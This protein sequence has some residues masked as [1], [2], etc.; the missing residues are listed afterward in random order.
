MILID[1]SKFG[2][3]YSVCLT[4]YRDG[5][6]VL[7]DTLSKNIKKM[8]YFENLSLKTTRKGMSRQ[9]QE[10]CWTKD[11]WR[12]R[13]G[14]IVKISSRNRKRSRFLWIRGGKK[15]S[16]VRRGGADINK[17]RFLR[18]ARDSKYMKIPGK[19]T[20][21]KY[22]SDIF[23]KMEKMTSWRSQIGKKNS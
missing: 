11:L 13:D 3:N 9:K 10:Q 2:K 21:P 22:L 18:C 17:Y 15:R 16:I 14:R 7:Q 23:G 4:R 19:S 20:G 12:N 8:S 5:S 6:G 1:G